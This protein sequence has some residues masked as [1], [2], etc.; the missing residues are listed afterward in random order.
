LPDQPTPNFGKYQV[1]SILGEGGMGRVWS[2][3]DPDL[4]VHVAIKELKEQFRDQ[5]NLERFFREAQIA[6]KCRHQNIVLITDLSKTPPYFVMEFLEGQELAVYT[7]KGKPISLALMARVLGQVCDGL[8]FLHGRGI[9]HRDLK[10]AN[11]M[12]LKDGT[13]KITD[14]GI[15]KAPFGQKTMTQVIMGTIPYMSPEQISTPLQVDGRSDLWSLGVITYEILQRK[16][17]FPGEGG[18][19]TMFH[20]VHSQPEQPRDLPPSVDGPLRALISK[21]LQK[22]VD[23][24]FRT[25]LEFKEMLLAAVRAAPDPEAVVFPYEPPGMGT[26]TLQPGTIADVA[27]LQQTIERARYLVDEIEKIPEERKAL[28]DSRVHGKASEIVRMARVLMEEKNQ[29]A[30]VAVIK[31]LESQKAALESG[32]ARGIARVLSEAEELSLDGRHADALEAYRRVLAA[33]S[34]NMEAKRGAERAAQAVQEQQAAEGL[35]ARGAKLLAD[36]SVADA[37]EVLQAAVEMHPGHAEG[38]RLLDEARRRGALRAETA[39][40]LRLAREALEARSF[41]AAQAALMKVLEAEPEN[42]E[43]RELASLLDQERTRTIHADALR[44]EG[45]RFFE[46]ENWPQARIA[47]STLLEILPGDKEAAEALGTIDEMEREA[48]AR[49]AVQPLAGKLSEALDALGAEVDQ[50]REILDEEVVRRVRDLVLRSRRAEASADRKAIEAALKDVE[51]MRRTVSQSVA[52][53]EQARKELEKVQALRDRVTQDL[54]ALG[55]EMDGARE[56]LDAAL[57]SKVKDLVVKGRRAES[58]TDAPAMQA[59]LG[60]IESVRKEMRSSVRRAEEARKELEKIQALRD[61]LAKELDDLGAEVD[62]ARE[63]LDD[64]FLGKVRDLSLRGRKA[65]SGADAKA[66]QAALSEAESVRKEIRA[67]VQR[68]AEARKELEQVLALR[69]KVPQGLEALGAEVDEAR[70][71]LDDAF[72]RRVR[73]TVLRGRRAEESTE[74]KEIE[75]ALAEIDSTRKG[76]GEA[77]KRAAETA[78][79]RVEPA[80]APLRE[81]PREDHALLGPALANKA[82]QAVGRVEALFKKLDA[83]GILAEEEALRAVAQEIGEQRKAVLA[84]G[85]AAIK[86]AAAPLQALLRSAERSLKEA[87]VRSAREAMARAEKDAAGPRLHVLSG[88]VDALKK[89]RQE[90]EREIQETLRAL[91][92]AVQKA[93]APVEAKAAKNRRAVARDAELSKKVDRLRREVSAVQGQT[94]VEALD[95]LHGEISAVAI[96]VDLLRF[97]PH[98]LGAAVVLAGVAGWFTYDYWDAHRLHSFELRVSPWGQIVTLTSEDAAE[99]PAPPP[100]SSPFHALQLVRGTW[101]LVVE[102]KETGGRESLT[103]TVPGQNG[104]EVKLGAPDFKRGLEEMLSRDPYFASEP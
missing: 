44:Q 65:E 92:E 4:E 10:P 62:E 101:T 83:R 55:V 38:T 90:V 59:V 84:K 6:A 64:A 73:E 61:R 15:S 5:N 77:L 51:A 37:I 14:F 21:A 57:L 39:A 94:S 85:A 12:I 20:I 2:A 60:E 80:L 33:D 95:R 75:A 86:E 49:E 35:V 81:I 22:K 96:P 43:A 52:Q 56:S 47:W 27:F 69:D 97:L 82:V 103:V 67:A 16:L 102:N 100:A 13:V 74:R 18:I 89:A 3:F 34:R 79:K 88:H 70:D 17:P 71:L 31:D 48:K 93:W 98:A 1:K 11:I 24:R 66:I 9:S 40:N 45:R 42:A 36:G 41:E 68:A 7:K 23:D 91:R 78:L 104:A 32:L 53:A 58:G 99:T 46:A 54:E 63:G 8:A 50:V 25:A 29:G 87:T 76:I 19:D 30:L 72:L 28:L 26:V